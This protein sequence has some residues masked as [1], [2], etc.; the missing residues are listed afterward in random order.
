MSSILLGIVMFFQFG[1][2]EKNEVI[3]IHNAV[4]QKL[5]S[6]EVSSKGDY[7]GQCIAL[8]VNPIATGKFDIQIPAGTHFISDISSEQDI[9]VVEDQLL[10][11]DGKSTKTFSVEGFCSQH[12]NSSPDVGSTFK[13]TKT[14][15]S[16]LLDLANFIKGKGYSEGT[17][18]SAVWAVSDG[19][20]I[21]AIFEEDKPEVKDLRSYVCEITDKPNPWYNTQQEYHITETRRIES[22][23]VVVEGQL[24]YVVTEKGKMRLSV[25]KANGELVRDIFKDVQ[26]AQTGETSFNFKGKVKGWEEGG[27]EVKVFINDKMIHMMPFEV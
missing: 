15:N 5:I 11:M 4:A 1:S 18:Q 13:M 24:T 6:V 21:A 7:S 9:F 14:N 19:E 17:K 23:P 26:I 12:D 10:A 8:T 20:T 16:K 3:D 2:V 22:T 25:Y 27:Y